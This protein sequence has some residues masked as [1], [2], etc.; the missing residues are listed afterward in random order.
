MTKPIDIT[1][2]LR[3]YVKSQRNTKQ[4]ERIY[5]WFNGDNMNEFVEYNGHFWWGL[6]CSSKNNQPKYI[7]DF[8][9]KYG[10]SKGLVYLWDVIPT[11]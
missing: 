7:Y 2:E 5:Q 10:E 3:D 4:G 8:L 11:M 6:T 9:K 1:N